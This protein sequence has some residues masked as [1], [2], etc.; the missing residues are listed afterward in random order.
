[1]TKPDRVRCS[2]VQ[3]IS[4]EITYG[5]VVKIFPQSMGPAVQEVVVDV[6]KANGADARDGGD[7][8]ANQSA[9]GAA[10]FLPHVGLLVKIV[11]HPRFTADEGEAPA[12]GKRQWVSWPQP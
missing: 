12:E 4:G 9:S 11:G 5:K 8:L 6:S 3:R 1:M 2:S 7:A 10:A